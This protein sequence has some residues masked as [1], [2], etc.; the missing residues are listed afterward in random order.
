[1]A[2]C[3]EIR[4]PLRGVRTMPVYVVLVNWTDQGIRNVK[5]SPKRSDAFIESAGKM[6]CRVREILYT[7]GAY[8]LVTVIEA[9]DDETASRL[10]LSVGMRGNVRSVTMRAFTKDEMAKIIAGLP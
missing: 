6:G 4:A 1:M 9:P 2:A 5:D 3:R 8:D 7:T 10:T